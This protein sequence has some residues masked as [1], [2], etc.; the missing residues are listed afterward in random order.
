MIDIEIDKLTNSIEN[1]LTG[2]CFATEVS[3]LTPTDMKNISKKMGWLF[4]WKMEFKH[5][6]RE[7][8]KLTISGSPEMIQGLVSIT[9]NVDHVYL[10]LIESAPFNL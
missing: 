2:D 10:H 1:V 9:E 6:G 7:V 5:P 3:L 4:N 8:Y